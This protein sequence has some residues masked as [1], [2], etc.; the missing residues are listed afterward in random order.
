MGVLVLFRPFAP[1]E[2]PVQA[3]STG[4]LSY[5]A[6]VMPELAYRELIIS[7]C[8]CEIR[9]LGQLRASEDLGRDVSFPVHGQS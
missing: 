1:D 5:D 9:E 6:T 8:F 2:E 7:L 4:S 3:L